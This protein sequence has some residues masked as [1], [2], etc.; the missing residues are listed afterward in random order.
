MTADQLRAGILA[1]M[2]TFRALY[3]AESMTPK[4]HYAVHLPTRLQ[5]LGYLPNCFSLERKHKL[6]ERFGDRVLNT[7]GAW[8]E[9]VLRDVSTQHLSTLARMDQGHF[10]GDPMLLKARAAPKRVRDALQ[11]QLP[12]PATITTASKARINE[13]ERVRRDDVV[14]VQ[15]PEQDPMV[16]QICL[17]LGIELGQRVHALAVVQ[18]WR[19]VQDT[20]RLYKCCVMPQY[21][22]CL[23]GDI[24]AALIWGG[25]DIRTVCKPVRL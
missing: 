2:R 23:V 16:G 10:S 4:F 14:L 5:E 19:I 9:G 21:A 3:G 1:H 20:P 7:A 18:Q 12:F 24:V 13:F 8:H 22:V 25:T 11:Q 17:L 15:G 6:V